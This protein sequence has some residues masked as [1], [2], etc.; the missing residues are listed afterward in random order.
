MDRPKLVGD[1]V[2]HWHK[3]SERRRTVAFAVSVSHSIHI[4][5]EFIRSG[6][7]AEHI[8]GGTPKDEVRSWVRSKMIAFAKRRAVA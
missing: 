1:I 5:D 6:V 8:D 4:R 2:T 3:Y 7:R